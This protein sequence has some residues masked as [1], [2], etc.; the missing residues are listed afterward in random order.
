MNFTGV[1]II[2]VL[3]YIV[4]EIYKVIFKGNDKAI[5]LIPIIMAITGAIISIA[6]FY[7]NKKMLYDAENIWIALEIGIVSGISSTGANQL[8]KQ[9]FKKGDN[10]QCH[11]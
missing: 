9:L 5:K 6:I 2:V 8:I 1:P 3:C 11:F 7:T 4:A 10:N